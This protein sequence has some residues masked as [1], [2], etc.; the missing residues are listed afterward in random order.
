MTV[1]NGR[2]SPF[3]QLTTDADWE[4]FTGGAGN[5]DGVVM[6]PT[7]SL[8]PSFDVPGRNIVMAAGNC[9]VKGKLWSTDANVSTAIPAASASNR[10]DRLVMRLN[11]TAGTA[12]AFLQPVVITGT[13]SGSPVI[14][15]I[16][17]SPT[18]NWDLPICHWT[19]T[20]A[21]GLTSLVDER[22]DVGRTMHSGP[23][24]NMPTWLIRPTLFYQTDLNQVMVW[25]GSSWLFLGQPADT[26][27]NMPAMSAGWS[28]GQTAK[29]RLNGDGDLQ[30]VFRDLI[31][32]TITDGTTIWGA[33]TFSG[34]YLVTGP[35]RMVSYA[36]LQGLDPGSGRTE[37]CALSFESDGSVTVYG[38]ASAATRL[39]FHG[40]I[41]L[42]G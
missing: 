18:G 27:H 32:G 26:V 41:P 36:Q 9:I 29:Y 3:L 25:N 10:I 37:G 11:R 13:P 30:V 42:W 6:N 8:A 39:D 23:A 21:G 19:S 17:Q 16:T 5:G 4:S 15:A 28:I 7:T 38:V 34:N 2:P 1:T 40:T 31:P 12:I 22:Y 24:A 35:R 20:S 33:G 14:P